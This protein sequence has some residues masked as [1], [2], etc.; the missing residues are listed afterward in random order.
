MLAHGTGT[1]HVLSERKML[2]ASK[3]CVIPSSLH[4][5]QGGVCRWV[6]SSTRDHSS[7]LL[8]PIEQ[9]KKKKK[10]IVKEVFFTLMIYNKLCRFSSCLTQTYKDIPIKN[11]V[12]IDFF[13]FNFIQ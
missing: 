2:Y 10:S 4:Y 6:C 5:L 7:T 11:V 1:N 3:C 9:S 13:K 12:S 8:T